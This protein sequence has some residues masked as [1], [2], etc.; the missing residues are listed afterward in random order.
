MSGK[1]AKAMLD[2]G[3]TLVQ[4]YTGMVYEGIG[5]A[6]NICKH[7]LRAESTTDTTTTEA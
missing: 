2:A 1:D 7:L 6:G 5:F 3:A 4:V